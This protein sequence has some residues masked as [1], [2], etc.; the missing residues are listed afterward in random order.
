MVV[1]SLYVSLLVAL[2]GLHYSPTLL[3]LGMF[4]FFPFPSQHVFP[5]PGRPTVDTLLMRSPLLPPSCFPAPYQ[6]QQ[7]QQER[8]RREPGG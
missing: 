3:R 7:T 6:H 4:M 1:L 5:W 8:K 2:L